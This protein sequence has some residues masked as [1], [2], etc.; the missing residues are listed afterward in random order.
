MD[1]IIDISFIIPCHNLEFYIHPL[2]LSI[3]ALD[4]KDIKSEFIFILDDC[5]DHTESIIKHFMTGFNYS[6]IKCNHHSCGL[7]R[8]EGLKVAKGEFIWFLD[9]DDWIIYPPAAK[10]CI[11]LMRNND[12]EIIRVLYVSNYYKIFYPS[13]VWQ[14]IYRHSLI[15]D[16]EFTTRQPHEDV[17]FMDKVLKKI[18]TD[19]IIVYN[20]P[21]YYYNYQ[22]PGSNMTQYMTTGKIEP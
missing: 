19:D 12:L 6:I 20:I 14:Y 15:N 16:I 1:N 9:G 22:R 10:E 7:S 17:E 11:E 21:T 5:I 2:L 4:L 18:Q 13:M 3:Q 8:N